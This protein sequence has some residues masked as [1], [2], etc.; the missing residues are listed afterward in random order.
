MRPAPGPLSPGGGPR[1]PSAPVSFG[2]ALARGNGL[3]GRGFRKWAFHPAM[4]FGSPRKW[5][6]EGGPRPNPHEGL[7]FLFFRS[8]QGVEEGISRGSVVPAAFDGEVARLEKDF[9]GQT[10]YVRHGL[11]EGDGRRLFTIYGHTAPLAGLGPVAAGEVVAKVAG[12]A[13]VKPH[14]HLSLALVP[15]SLPV[16]A[17]SWRTMA[18]APEV[19]LLDPLCLVPDYEILD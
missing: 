9:I 7:D 4:L 14:L 19:E 3:H 8:A 13:P 1:L 17:L 5:W 6:G 10:L 11:A 16:E 18:A 15:D 2:E 12:G